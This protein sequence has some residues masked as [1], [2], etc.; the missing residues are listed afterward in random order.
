M[1]LS[2]L[3]FLVLSV[4]FLFTACEKGGDIDQELMGD[5]KDELGDDK[6]EDGKDCFDLLYP[7]SYTM[8]DGTTVTGNN[9]AEI[10]E[11]FKNWYEDHPDSKKEPTLQYPVEIVYPEKDT[12]FTINNEEEMKK[13]W[14]KCDD[15]GD[16]WGDDKDLDKKDCFEFVYPISYTMP[17]G[18]VIS[19]GPEALEE[20]MKEWYA[21]HDSAEKPV[22]VYPVQIVFPDNDQP[23]T[24]NNEEEFA[25]AKKDCKNDWGDDKDC[26]ELVYPLTYTMP[27]G[28]TISGDNKENLWAAIK[29]WYEDH[30]DFAAEP[31]LNYPVQIA[32]PD[33][34]MLTTINNEE[35]M[36]EAKE[37][38]E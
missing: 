35:E 26:F 18:S 4:F 22:L 17:D 30:P 20:A 21:S 28:S 9:E 33:N 12:P 15:K 14:K 7:V 27:N 32:Y 25:E 24:I 3:N 1:K 5:D 29:T 2:T 31:T 36:K 8:P 19:G 38:C 34:D 6:G 37:G 16:D 23:K 13:A 11:A 10:D